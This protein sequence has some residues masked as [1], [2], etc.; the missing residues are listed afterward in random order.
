MGMYLGE[1]RRDQAS[2]TGFLRTAKGEQ[3]TEALKIVRLSGLWQA[4]LSSA[5]LALDGDPESKDLRDVLDRRLTR[6][7]SHKTGG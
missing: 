6:L 3:A 4:Y 2:L 7:L 5:V 1:D